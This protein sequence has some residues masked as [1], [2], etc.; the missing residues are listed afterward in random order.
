MI[1]KIREIAGRKHKPRDESIKSL[2]GAFLIQLEAEQ[3]A[4]ALTAMEASSAVAAKPPETM[5]NG[6]TATSEVPTE[7]LEVL[8]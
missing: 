3:D 1:T 2:V 7:D 6:P 5:A 8:M 4:A